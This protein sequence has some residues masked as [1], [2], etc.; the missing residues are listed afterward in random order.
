M[1][2]PQTQAKYY[3]VQPLGSTSP[4]TNSW[5]GISLYHPEWKPE[6]LLHVIQQSLWS[7]KTTEPHSPHTFFPQEELRALKLSF[8][9]QGGITQQF[10][11]GIS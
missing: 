10:A 5:V 2:K 4:P 1:I 11:I 6:L 9:P 3:G 8:T 7:R